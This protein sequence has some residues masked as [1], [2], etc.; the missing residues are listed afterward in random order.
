[1]IINE[2]DVVILKNGLKAQIVEI[3]K[4]GEMFVADVEE[5]NGWEEDDTI[6]VSPDDIKEI[7]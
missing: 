2:Y 4:N 7:L 6:F 5:D 3:L 1:M